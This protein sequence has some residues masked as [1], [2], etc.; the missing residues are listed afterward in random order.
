MSEHRP[1]RRT[2]LDFLWGLDDNPGD[3][4]AAELRAEPAG[5]VVSGYPIAAS[6]ARVA[7]QAF[8]TSWPFLSKCAVKN[9][10]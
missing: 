8:A 1:H 4:P 5:S 3:E 2:S 10:S 7:E 9:A 6:P